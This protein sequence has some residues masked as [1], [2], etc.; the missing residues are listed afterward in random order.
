[1]LL[2]YIILLLL[3]LPFFQFA[4]TAEAQNMPLV[5]RAPDGSCATSTEICGDGIDQDCDGKDV[6]C[7]GTDKDRD[8]FD[9]T[10]DCDDADRKIFPGISVACSV[11]SKAGNR[12]CQSNGSFSACV[13][14]PLCEAKGAGRCYYVSQ[15]TGSDSNPGTFE[16]PFKSL[17][18]IVSYYWNPPAISRTLKPG[19]V[20]YIL[21]GLYSETYTYDTT[22][23]GLFLRN[24]HGTPEAPIL[25]KAYP[26]ARV[27]LKN[28][29]KSTPIV[30]W[31]GSNIIFEGIEI[32][33]NYSDGMHFADSSALEVR[34]M[35]IHDNDGIDNDN[36]AGIS[37]KHTN[38]LRIHHNMI[39]DN[40][41]RTNAD[42]GGNKTENS[43]NMVFFSG[44][45]IRVDYNIIFQ[46]PPTSS[47]KGGACV[48]YKHGA[49]VEGSKFEV[50][51]NMMWNCSFNSVGSCTFNT[52]VHHNL[53]LDSGTLTVRDF[54]GPAFNQDIIFEKNTL[55]RTSA[56]EHVPSTDY[57][58]IGLMTYR[59]NIVFDNQPTYDNNRAMVSVLNY[60]SDTLYNTI[61]SGNLLQFNDNCYFNPNTSPRFS[62]FS[63]PTFGA[64]GG[65]YDLSAWRGLGFDINSTVVDPAFTADFQSTSPACIGKGWL[66][67]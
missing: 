54:G 32:A 13:E 64:L 31:S 41:D 5:F 4:A 48:V 12:T 7:P 33:G 39:H 9:S 47:P 23:R 22:T 26:G 11:N 30:I 8:G 21:S 37:A 34:N 16:A 20:V 49:T 66:A 51:H 18:T 65:L 17:L 27:L 43:R 44:G 45:N 35:W 59:N 25:I 52:R 55:V 62:L 46:T 63:S 36:I 53:I 1:M 38:G 19:D 60:G 29:A 24:I 15:M 61:M 50:D 3:S 2:N 6:L 58:P 57:R 10:A 67:P 56:L 28:S 40:Y 42:T 14:R